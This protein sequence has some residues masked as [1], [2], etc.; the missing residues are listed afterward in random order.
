MGHML[1]GFRI[2]ENMYNRL[3]KQNFILTIDCVVSLLINHEPASILTKVTS[4]WLFSLPAGILVTWI[5]FVLKI[6]ERQ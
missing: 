2:N 3:N 1:F 4:P 6:S 5:S